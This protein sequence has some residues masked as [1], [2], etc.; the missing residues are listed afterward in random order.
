MSLFLLELR[1]GT[2]MIKKLD[3]FLGLGA[4]IGMSLCVF[5]QH[6]QYYMVYLAT[7][8]IIAS[9]CLPIVLI[10]FFLVIVDIIFE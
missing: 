1:E 2:K 3:S 7:S 5:G 4:L 9:I 6:T 8:L 10:Q